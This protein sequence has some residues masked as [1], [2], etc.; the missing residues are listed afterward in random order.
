MLGHPD[1]HDLQP[2]L[3]ALRAAVALA[4]GGLGGSS[5]LQAGLAVD[6]PVLSDQGIQHGFHGLGVPGL[7]VLR[8]LIYFYLTDKS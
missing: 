1:C 3:A 8:G 7:D 2:P 5:M 4:G 6:H